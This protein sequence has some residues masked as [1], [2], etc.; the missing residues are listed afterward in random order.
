[1]R[2][3][4]AGLSRMKTLEDFDFSKAPKVAPTRIQE[5]ANECQFCRTSRMWRCGKLAMRVTP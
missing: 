4:A 2:G 3:P 1:M 5:L